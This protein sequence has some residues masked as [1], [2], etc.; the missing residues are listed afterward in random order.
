MCVFYQDATLP[1][2]ECT[3]QQKME[4][5]L[6]LK[7]AVK[8]T[9]KVV[10]WKAL[11]FELEV[12]HYILTKIEKNHKDKGV[13][14]CKSAL[15]EHWFNNDEAKS[16]EKLKRATERAKT[17]EER[18]SSIDS[19]LSKKEEK[20]REEGYKICQA[21]QQLQ[22]SFMVLEKEAVS[23]HNERQ[24]LD[25][26]L[27]AERSK[28]I[29]AQKKWKKEDEN[30]QQKA[31]EMKDVLD[32][33]SIDNFREL[34][35]VKKFI[36]GKGIPQYHTDQSIKAYLYKEIVQSEVERCEE[37]KFRRYQMVRYKTNI[38]YLREERGKWQR[39][40]EWHLADIQRRKLTTMEEVGLKA[41]RMKR[42]HEKVIQ[43][44]KETQEKFEKHCD[45]SLEK[46]E[47]DIDLYNGL[48]DAHS[49]SFNIH[50]IQIKEAIANLKTN[51]RV[52]RAEIEQLKERISSLERMVAAVAGVGATVGGVLGVIGGPIGVGIGV[53]IGS[54]LG[55]GFS[56]LLTYDEKQKVQRELDHAQNALRELKRQ[57]DNDSRA[58]QDCEATE[59]K[60]AELLKT[61]LE[62]R[63]ERK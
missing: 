26:K 42:I 17:T 48:L 27:E 54:A 29:S 21:S 39:L 34:P 13:D 8:F 44:Y 35:H 37:I 4:E 43:E 30:W 55:A 24:R 6:D 36:E 31:L 20:L 50:Y 7:N 63:E 14:R 11:G 51:I 22:T 47:N 10:K 49:K 61:W 16:W 57:L 19:K 33:V 32:E 52:K 45:E 5:P 40:L 60:A 38:H 23:I 15:L 53:G 59:Q 9:Q 2:P 62:I 41:E 18:E 12:E 56:Y 1:H 46:I 25:E 28:L 3:G 58:L